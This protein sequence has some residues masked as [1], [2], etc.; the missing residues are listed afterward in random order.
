[1]E[2]NCN[3]NPHECHE[4]C[5]SADGLG[6]VWPTIAARRKKKLE[7]LAALPK[8]CT[9]CGCLTL[10]EDWRGSGAKNMH[11]SACKRLH[12]I[13]QQI[14]L[15]SRRFATVI[16][17]ELRVCKY[18]DPGHGWIAVPMQWLEQFGLVGQVSCYSYRRGVTAYLEEDCDA[19]LFRQTAEQHGFRLFVDYRHTNDNSPIRSYTPFNEG[20]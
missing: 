5:V 9:F 11:C 7:E 20:N 13:Q 4:S 2:T 16:G 15:K 3:S 10:V 18:E 8:F 19:P 14:T 12:P 1:M 17:K 6:T